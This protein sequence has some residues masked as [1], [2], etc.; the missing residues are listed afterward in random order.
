MELL[1]A[2]RRKH[3]NVT[4]IEMQKRTFQQPASGSQCVTMEAIKNFLYGFTGTRVGEGNLFSSPFQS[5]AYLHLNIPL[6]L[7]GFLELVFSHHG[8]GPRRGSDGCGFSRLC[9]CLLLLSSSAAL[10]FLR[11]RCSVR[12]FI[13]DLPGFLIQAFRTATPFWNSL[14]YTHS[15]HTQSQF[16]TDQIPQQ[17]TCIATL[18]VLEE[19]HAEIEAWARQELPYSGLQQLRK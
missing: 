18:M 1:E 13:W 17:Q 6:G 15:A 8:L 9:Y 19:K 7:H 4:H 10:F 11:H 16:E 5:S 3:R 12:L 2:K 14:C